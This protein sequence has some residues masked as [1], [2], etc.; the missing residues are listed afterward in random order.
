M[1]NPTNRTTYNSQIKPNE[2]LNKYLIRYIKLSKDLDIPLELVTFGKTKSTDSHIHYPLKQAK[3]NTLREL[4]NR[5]KVIA[6]NPIKGIAK[7]RLPFIESFIKD[8]NLLSLL[9]DS[10]C[11]NN[12]VSTIKSHETI[13]SEI[14][15]LKKFHIFFEQVIFELNEIYPKSPN[16]KFEQILN[17]FINRIS[18]YQDNNPQVMDD[19]SNIEIK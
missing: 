13:E 16:E 11:R 17:Y 12:C 6:S 2:F 18:Q 19:N 14:E 4:L 8:N 9:E 3:I 15:I 1:N 10:E 7:K 5:Y